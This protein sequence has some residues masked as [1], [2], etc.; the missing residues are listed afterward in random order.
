MLK[1]FSAIQ[2][3]LRIATSQAPRSDDQEAVQRPQPT[4]F[5]F[6]TELYETKWSS[7]RFYADMMQDI[8]EMVEAKGCQTRSAT[9]WSELGGAD[10]LLVIDN[11]CIIAFARLGMLEGL[12]GHRYAL[13]LGENIDPVKNT[14]VGW[15]LAEYLIPLSFN[16]NN[17][18][19]RLI[20]GAEKVTWQN[21]PVHQLLLR[22]LPKHRVSY[23][24]INGY[25]GSQLIPLYDGP[26]D[27]A[28]FSSMGR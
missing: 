22:L 17:I 9:A 1:L 23:F 10:S 8:R 19:S 25:R 2:N 12:L 27:V 13:I 3:G 5:V 7:I 18:L 24:P 21:E 26:L 20:K 11:A 16:E 4:E 28:T 15:D 14:F 6:F